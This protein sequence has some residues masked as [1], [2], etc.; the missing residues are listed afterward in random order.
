MQKTTHESTNRPTAKHPLEET[1]QI[2]L[3]L[4]EETL[5]M[6]R[7]HR[8][9]DE[10]LTVFAGKA[11]IITAVFGA[12]SIIGAIVTKITSPIPMM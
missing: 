10:E 5:A 6:L 7:G 4:S 11:L 9:I 8:S 1:P 3:V 12:L 2:Q